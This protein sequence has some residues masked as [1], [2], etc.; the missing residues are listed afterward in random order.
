MTGGDNSPLAWFDHRTAGAPVV[1][2]DRARQFLAATTQEP[3]GAR[4]AAA[5]RAALAA[6]TDAGSSRAAALDLLAADAL[7]TL[8][9]VEAAE[10]VPSSLASEAVSLRNFVTS[11]A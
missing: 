4:L 1:L 6:A 8:A 11:V 9:L 5:G 3:L 10:R 2:R 7:I